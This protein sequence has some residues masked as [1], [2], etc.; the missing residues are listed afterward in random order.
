MRRLFYVPGL[1]SLIVLA[2]AL[3][4]FLND[5]EVWVQERCIQM[6]FP[7]EATSKADSAWMFGSWNIPQRNWIELRFSGGLAESG[8]ALSDFRDHVSKIALCHDTLTGV[9][10]TLARNTKWETV[11]AAVDILMVDSIQAWMIDRSD[12][13]AFFPKA[14]GTDTASESLGAVE[15]PLF[16][17]GTDYGPKVSD[18]DRVIERA[19]TPFNELR[20]SQLTLWPILVALMIL[21]WFVARQA[22]QKA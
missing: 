20:D 1:L 15:L 18:F 3:M 4:W 6:T 19:L 7:M 14:E 16:V 9:H 8:A 10:V 12:I 22:M 2:P 5:K 11:I 21:V 13:T 17:C